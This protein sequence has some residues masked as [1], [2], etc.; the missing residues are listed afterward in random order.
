[1]GRRAERQ[2]GAGQ[3]DTDEQSG[4]NPLD[5]HDGSSMTVF[6]DVSVRTIRRFAERS[7]EATWRV[8]GEQPVM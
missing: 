5:L 7:L 4:D 6:P 3:R 1:V 2:S 8:R